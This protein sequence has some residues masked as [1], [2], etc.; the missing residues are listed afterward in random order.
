MHMYQRRQP[1]KTRLATV[2]V[3]HRLLVSQ[4]NRLN[5]TEPLVP[6]IVERNAIDMVQIYGP[7]GLP[8][9]DEGHEAAVGFGPGSCGL[10]SM[11]KSRD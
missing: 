9:S 1:S 11:F 5:R 7:T 10:G 6:V 4:L 2:T 8:L 3:T